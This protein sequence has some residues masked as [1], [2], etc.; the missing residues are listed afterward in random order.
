MLAFSLAAETPIERCRAES[1]ALN[2]AKTIATCTAAGENAE[3]TSAERVEAFK[4][5]G[6]A[7][8]VEGEPDLAES[9]FSKM[10]ALDP[11]TTLGTDAGPNVTK[12]LDKARAKAPKPV[13]KVEPEKDPPHTTS[14]T[15]PTTSTTTTT[16]STSA[17]STQPEALAAEHPEDRPKPPA[18]GLPMATVGYGVA[19]VGGAVA[20][21]S[22]VLLSGAAYDLYFNRVACGAA[23][24][25]P[26]APMLFGI[27]P[28]ADREKFFSD[29]SAWMA[30]ALVGTVLGGAAVAGGTVLALGAQPTEPA[31]APA[32]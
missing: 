5:L 18:A 32:P 11:N 2:T 29:G 21:G 3:L 6:V 20:V 13:K 10:L 26:V 7:L 14:S 24:C 15:T 1:Q 31:A 22:L 16:T 28:I 23:A 4:L 30:A 27:Y 9:A 8:V 12:V 17:T 19:G 25:V